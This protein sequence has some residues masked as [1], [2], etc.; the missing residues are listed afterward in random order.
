MHPKSIFLSLSPMF[1]W[2]SF[3]LLALHPVQAAV[4]EGQPLAANALRI[5]ETL[6]Y[7]GAPLPNADRIQLQAAAFAEDVTEIQS[8]LDR[9]SLIHLAINPEL[10]VKATRGA[11][12]PVLQQAGYT[13]VIIRV[14]ND[15]TVT[16][17]VRMKSPQAGPVYSGASTNILGRQAQTE[18]N[19]NEN[20]QGEHRFLEVEMYEAA[21]MTDRLSGLEIEY[22]VGLIY[23]SEAGRRE[24]KLQFDVG[25]GTEDLGFRSEVSILFQIQ[26]A[27]E[28][29]LRIVD[30]NGVPTTARLEFRDSDAKVYPPQPK[31]LA[32]DFFFQP[33]IYRAD[34]TTVQLPP[35][36][37]TLTYSRGPEYRVLKKEI[38]IL[39]DHTEPIE[40]QLE[41][42]INPEEFGYYSGDH[43]IHGGG[44]SHYDNPTQGVTPGD[45]FQQVKGE[46]LNVGCVLTW[47]PCFDHQR[48]YFS[49][50]ADTVSESKTVLKYDLEISGFGS[51]ALGHVC[52]LNLSSQTYPGS[53]GTKTKGWPTWT[54]PVMRWAKEQGGVTGYPHS[55]LQVDARQAAAWWMQERDTDGD[56]VISVGEERGKLFAEP[57]ALMDENG[58]LSIS[59]AELEKSADRAADQLPN[60]APPAMNGGGAME[61]FVTAA[62]GVCDFISAMDTS[63][64]SEWNTWYHLMNCGLPIQLSGETDFPCMSSRRVGQG[65]VYAQL[66]HVGELDF[67]S[68]TRAVADGRSYVSDG[69]AHAMQFKVNGQAPGPEY[70]Q[71][72]KPSQ[73]HVEAVIAFAPERPRAVAYGT[74]D[75]ASGR[76]TVGDTINLHA[77]RNEDMVRGGAEWVELVWNGEVVDR[78]KVPADGKTHSITFQAQIN[79]SGWM[80]IRHFPQ[81]H[82]N[83]VRILV[84]EKPIRASRASAIWCAESIRLLWRNRSSFISA[85]ER[86]EALESYERAVK[87]YLKIAQEC[88]DTGLL[89]PESENSSV[90]LKAY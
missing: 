90:G 41:R 49:P 78:Q 60:L 36:K 48:N 83:P 67:Q 57:F 66:G 85:S 20:F 28:I 75:P 19:N 15:A 32:P 7:L 87:Q 6:D 37:F 68:W 10:R 11:A 72:E 79:Q 30:W 8:L 24:V 40:V 27:L 88:Q 63:R 45:M 59:F 70:L 22:L 52:L 25:Q 47:G 73:V 74:L 26:P 61:I 81:M 14:E 51:A 33:Q 21:P 44:C 31:R 34:K 84:N 56:G 58:D 50:I 29:P 12:V 42:W 16:R 86:T 38:E 5:I 82:T 35:G 55:A 43:H 2:V 18:L 3:L 13:P 77:P 4:V 17:S 69:F 64:V 39:P 65:R 1:L 62:E 23:S 53:E 71:L 80:A 46:G 54:V 9:Y 76:R 89:V